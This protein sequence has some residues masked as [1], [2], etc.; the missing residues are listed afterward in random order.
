M[1]TLNQDDVDADAEGAIVSGGWNVNISTVQTKTP[2]FATSKWNRM[3]G[4]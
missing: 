4:D 3:L 1:E 2:R